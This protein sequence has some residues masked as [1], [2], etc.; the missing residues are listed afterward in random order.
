MQTEPNQHR[1][2]GAFLRSRRERITP[3]AVGLPHAG[4]RRTPGL[5]REEHAACSPGSG[6]RPGD[7]RYTRL[8]DE[9]KARSPEVRAWWPRYDVQARHGGRKRLRLAGRG[10]VEFACTAFHLAEH[11]EHTLVIYSEPGQ[12][13]PGTRAP[14]KRG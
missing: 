11:P 10:V 9:L 4:R 3:D 8:I 5:R 12:P 6:R 14:A 1:E 13:H 2:L 7:P